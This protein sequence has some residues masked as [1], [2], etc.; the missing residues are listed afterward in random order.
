MSDIDLEPVAPADWRD[1]KKRSIPIKTIKHMYQRSG[2]EVIKAG[3]SRAEGSKER[4]DPA[5]AQHPENFNYI[6]EQISNQWLT[7]LLIEM[8]HYASLAKRRTFKPKDTAWA[9]A[10]KGHLRLVY[11]SQSAD[12]TRTGFKTIEASRRS[13]R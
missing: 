5:M 7:L 12:R 10:R 11:A 1:P 9:L 6:A 8:I 4:S 13:G 3:R 2:I